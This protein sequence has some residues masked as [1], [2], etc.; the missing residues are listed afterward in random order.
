MARASRLAACRLI[1]AAMA[2]LQAL[3][4]LLHAHPARGEASPELQPL[5]A[6]H[7]PAQPHESV[8]PGGH[9]APAPADAATA[10]DDVRRPTPE[11]GALG[12]PPAAL[13]HPLAQ[14]RHGAARGEP[15]SVFVAESRRLTGPARAPPALA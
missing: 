8:G 5:A 12:A 2:L 9:D 6:I 1:V 15:R 10:L 13:A 4:P 7:L 11:P 3:L 14:G